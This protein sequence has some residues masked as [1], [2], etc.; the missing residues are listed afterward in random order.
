MN[1]ISNIPKYDVLKLQSCEL[2]HDIIVNSVIM[3]K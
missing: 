3:A 2:K 1:V